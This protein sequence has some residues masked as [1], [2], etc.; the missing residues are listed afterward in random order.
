MQPVADSEAVGPGPAGE[1]GRTEVR[2]PADAVQPASQ[3]LPSEL[4]LR[5]GD[6]DGPA[7]QPPGDTHGRCAFDENV[8]ITR[9][10]VDV[11]DNGYGEHAPSQSSRGGTSRHDGT[12]PAVITASLRRTGD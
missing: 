10:Q 9:R 12:V 2:R 11:V 4:C 7:Y 8:A 1:L 5:V 6:A 3:P